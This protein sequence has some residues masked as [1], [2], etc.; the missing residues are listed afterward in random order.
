MRTLEYLTGEMAAL[1]WPVVVAGVG[2]SLLGAMLSVPVV[3]KRLAFIGQGVSH[4]AFGGAGVALV[5]GLTGGTAAVSLAYLGVVGMFCVLTALGVAW[6][7]SRPEG[8]PSGGAGDAR[9]Q[10]EQATGEDT[11]IGVFLVA[12]MA[13]GALLTH[14]HRQR[15][16]ASGGPRA[17][18]PSAEQILFGSILD[19]GWADAAIAWGVLGVTAITLTHTRRAMVFWLFDEPAASAFGVPVRPL[20]YLLLALLGVATVTA[21]KLAGAVLATALLVV[22]GA[23]ALRLT[24]RLHVALALACVSGLVGMLGGLVLSFE[25]DWPPGACVVT[26]LAGQFLAAWMLGGMLHRPRSASG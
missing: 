20:R 1:M 13:L 5:L 15:L 3:L 6:A 23:V 9:G 16:D 25:L 18:G 17:T 21:M 12:S 24:R 2:V 10:G 4:A 11:L 7:A 14:W 19:V 8:G 26:V 22:P